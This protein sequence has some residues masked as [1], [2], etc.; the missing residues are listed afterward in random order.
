MED[1]KEIIKGHFEGQRLIYLSEQ[2]KKQGYEFVFSNEIK[3]EYWNLAYITDNIEVDNIW[4]LIKIEMQKRNRIPVIYITS[5]LDIHVPQEKFIPIYQDVWMILDEQEEIKDAKVSLNIKIEKINS[6]TKEEIKKQC[7]QAIMDGFSGEDPNDPYGSL[8]IQYKYALEKSMQRIEETI[9]NK[10]GLLHSFA[11]YKEKIVGTLTAIYNE[12][13]GYI[14][15]VTTNKE[16]KRK[17]ICNKLLQESIKELR[18]KGIGTICL[19]TEKGFYTQEVYKRLG[20]K[21]ILIGTAYKEKD[22][23]KE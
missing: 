8:D 17:G 7:I 22:I 3:D 13:V 16:Y 12:K 1:I 2:I 23:K 14:Y 18:K 4:E 21:E 15:N 6:S 20:F 19:Q 9:E 10:C 5:N 11:S